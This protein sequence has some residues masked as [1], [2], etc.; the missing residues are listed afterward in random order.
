MKKVWFEH[1]AAKTAVV[2]CVLLLTATAS[3]AQTVISRARVGGYAEDLTYVASGKLKDNIVMINGFEVMAVPI[4]KNPKDK[5]K[6]ELTSIFSLKIPELDVLPTGLAYIESEGLFAFAS[7][8]NFKKLFL[9]DSE[10]A[11]KGTRTIQY[12]NSAYT[13]QH[14]E[15]MGYIPSSSPTF[16]DH[17]M[18]VVWD[19]LA[20][21]SVRIEIMRRDGVVVSELSNPG[22]PA[23][24]TQNLGDVAY[25][26]PNRLLVTAY[27]AGIWTMDFSGTILSGPVAAGGGIGEGIVQMSD[28]RI[29]AANFPQRL[30]VFDSNLNPQPA[31]DR[32]DIIGLNLNPPAGIAWDPDTNKLLIAHDMPGVFA[33]A[34]PGISSVPTSLDSAT[35]AVNTSSFPFGRLLTYLPGEHLIAMTHANPRKIVFF[36]SNG[37]FNSEVD[38]SSPTTPAP[39]LGQITGITYIPTTNEFA[40]SFNGA[41][42]N[43]NR[44]IVRRTLYILSRS[45]ALVR[46]LDLTDTGTGSIGGLAYYVDP[47][48]NERFIV[49]GSAG[50]V[51]ITD[52]NGDS[53]NASGFLI[54]EFNSRVKL[55]LTERADITAI[56]TGPMAGAFAIISGRTGEVVIFG[57]D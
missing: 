6:D 8:T 23:E 25:L 12:L 27:D 47:D 39:G 50:R 21:G 22:W 20:G 40:L 43:P 33:N 52:L 16:P 3:Q 35:Q 49:L 2:F 13:P 7:D 55:G 34:P 41:A 46:T 14:F 24:F 17:L 38:L 29:V 42:S 1:P 32:N 19:D 37:T 56:T 31:S 45:G 11:F 10:G 15:G 57:L 54:G 44:A 53:R 36:N 48:G 51:I 28:S 18:V 4:A 5:S 9:F 26:A 30:L